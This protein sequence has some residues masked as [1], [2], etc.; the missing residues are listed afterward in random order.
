MIA[1]SSARA[2][3]MRFSFA[4]S[5]SS[6]RIRFTSASV[7]SASLEFQVKYVA[8]LM[9]CLRDAPKTPTR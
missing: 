8:R 7:A 3:Y 2:G 9:A 1:F 4:L 6:A 5:A